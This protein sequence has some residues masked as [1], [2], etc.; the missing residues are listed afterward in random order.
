MQ[1]ETECH[2]CK[3]ERIYGRKLTQT[4]QHEKEKENGDRQHR[5]DEKADA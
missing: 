5:Q 3:Y 2:A 1:W 4:M